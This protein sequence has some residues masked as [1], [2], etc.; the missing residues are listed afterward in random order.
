LPGAKVLLMLPVVCGLCLLLQSAKKK[1]K[2]QAAVQKA[3]EQLEALMP[4]LI[5]LNKMKPADWV[6]QP[7]APRLCPQH[8]ARQQQPPTP[9]Y[10]SH[11]LSTSGTFLGLL[12]SSLRSLGTSAVQHSWLCSQQANPAQGRLPC[13][14]PPPL[15]M[16]S[17]DV[18]SPSNTCAASDDATTA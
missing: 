13:S 17:A 7:W 10:Q 12:G 5:N 4:N 8:P 11:L 14:R 9:L 15:L 6:R 16:S 3:L 2:D 1:G 18:F